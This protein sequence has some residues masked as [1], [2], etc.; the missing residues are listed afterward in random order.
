MGEGREQGIWA[1]FQEHGRSLWGF[2]WEN[3]LIIFVSRSPGSS[4]ASG[5]EVSTLWVVSP[6]ESGRVRRKRVQ[7]SFRRNNF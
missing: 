5:L 4:V 6:R 2:H 3:D 7:A 1:L